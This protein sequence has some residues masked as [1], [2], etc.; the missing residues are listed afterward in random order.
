MFLQ[1]TIDSVLFNIRGSTEVIVVLD[2]YWPDQ[3]IPQQ[4]NLVVIHHPESIGQRAATNEAARVSTASFI[5]K[6]DAHCAVGEGFDVVLLES[7]RELGRETIQVPRQYNHHAFDWVCKSCGEREYQGPTKPCKKCGGQR[8]REIVWKPRKSRLTTSWYFDRELKFGYWGQYRHRPEGQK[9]ISETMSCLGA[10]WY[11]DRDRY[12]ELDGLDEGHGGWGQMG[13][14]IAC[15]TWLSGGRLV[16][17]KKTWFSHMFRTQGGDFGFPYHLTV[18]AQK[19]ARAHSHDV[20]RRDAPDEMPKWKGATRPL[21]WLLDHFKPVKDWDDKEERPAKETNE[22]KEG[23][24]PSGGEDVPRGPAL[25]LPETGTR[26]I[27]YYSDCRPSVNLLEA[28]HRQLKRAAPDLPLVAVS[29]GDLPFGREVMNGDRYVSVGWHRGILTMFR[30]ILRGL[31]ELDTDVAFLAE[32]DMLYHPSH[33]TFAPPKND[34]YYYN[35]NVWKVRAEDG[36][37]LFYFTKQTSGLCA[38][39]KLL[40]EH[41]H[42]RVAKVIQNQRDLEARGEPIRRDGFS[43]HMGFEPGCHAPPRGVDDYTAE[44]WMSEYP[45]IDIRHSHNLT[46]SRWSQDQ[47]R[48]KR[49]CQGWQMTDEVPG[50]G[51]TKGRFQEILKGV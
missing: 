18:G 27:V 28:C 6:L 7:A 48:S 41:Y 22:T 29:L 42:R 24:V 11:V 36:Q 2:G 5:M 45:N 49:S 10:C 33:F 14:E 8:E 21:R 35:E 43:R 25:I 44:R 15:K 31:E 47:F 26:G 20:W 40:V 38:N 1:Q 16:C 4:P 34:V 17:N 13:T 32:H 39:R 3:G 23:A 50:W 37:A 19:R 9:E 30:Q 46:P 51:V 12:W